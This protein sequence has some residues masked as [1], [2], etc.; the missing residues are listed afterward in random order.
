MIV[1]AATLATMGAALSVDSSREGGKDPRHAEKRRMLTRKKS[2][3][4]IVAELKHA[5]RPWGFRREQW[6]GAEDALREL[7]KAVHGRTEAISMIVQTAMSAE[8]THVH[9]RL[10]GDQYRLKIQIERPLSAI[11]QEV[12]AYIDLP[13]VRDYKIELIDSLESWPNLYVDWTHCPEPWIFVEAEHNGMCATDHGDF[14]RM[15][16]IGV[17]DTFAYIDGLAGL[18]REDLDEYHRAMYRQGWGRP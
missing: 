6:A 13:D 15:L 10:I 2:V 1:T 18:G 12:P 17:R 4:N 5:P 3:V 14:F 9:A 16:S 7:A 11:S 8:K